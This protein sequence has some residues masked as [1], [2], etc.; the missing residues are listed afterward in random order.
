[1][2]MFK[3][4][5]PAGYIEQ[6]SQLFI[7]EANNLM[8]SDAINKIAPDKRFGF[9][10][11]YI[12]KSVL[13]N[14][15][16]M[17]SFVDCNENLAGFVGSYRKRGLDGVYLHYALKSEYR[18][19]GLS[20][21]MLNMFFDFDTVQSVKYPFRAIILKDNIASQKAIESIGFI[22][23]ISSIYSGFDFYE[24]YSNRGLSLSELGEMPRNV[25]VN[26]KYCESTLLG[27][28]PK[29]R[30]SRKKGK[31]DTFSSLF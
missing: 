7:E 24:Y 31:N 18:G 30:N 8:V 11:E 13:A 10:K 9:I 26:S 5:N 20:T 28:G 14:P 15:D 3:L 22:K 12:A 21:L 2:N 19:M 17:Y 16:Y 1:M 23:D 4:I 29:Q 6:L 25:Q 27:F